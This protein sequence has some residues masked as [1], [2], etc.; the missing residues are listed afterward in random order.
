ML[1]SIINLT[2]VI[3][4]FFILTGNEV[5]KGQNLVKTEILNS[6]TAKVRPILGSKAS[7][8]KVSVIRTTD[9]TSVKSVIIFDVSNETIETVATQ[10]SVNY[11]LLL[12]A[13]IGTGLLSKVNRQNGKRVYD[14]D[15]L[16]YLISAFNQL[17]GKTGD[18]PEV[19]TLWEFPVDD[20]FVIALS[21]QPGNFTKYVIT[22]DD[23]VFEIETTSALVMLKQLRDFRDLM[24]E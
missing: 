18:K 16:N 6:Y 8:L 21:L 11:N 2:Y 10:T 3:F 17:I 12:G 15:G 22:I 4:L 23:A 9:S 1:R 24:K 19:D 13:S 14:L 5:I 20:G 7:M